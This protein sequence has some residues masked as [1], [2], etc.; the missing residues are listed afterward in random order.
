MRN[1]GI[2]A[3]LFC[4]LYSSHAIDPAKIDQ[5]PTVEFP[6]RIGIFAQTPYG[7][8]YGICL[9][10]TPHTEYFTGIQ[11]A[12][13]GEDQQE[14]ENRG[15]WIGWHGELQNQYGMQIA[16]LNRT[17][18]NGTAQIAVGANYAGKIC[19]IQAAGLLNQSQTL[20][21]TQIAALGNLADTANGF[22]L[23][24]LLNQAES[25]SGAQIALFNVTGAPL[26]L[27][28]LLNEP[29]E[30]QTGFVFQLGLE[31]YSVNRKVLQIGLYNDKSEPGFQI[32]L[33]NHSRTGWINWMPL[34]NW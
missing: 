6:P 10:G 8:T 7:N 24:V 21:G 19:G 32:G 9:A 20:N 17:W 26:E 30:L 15:L 25:G 12:F 18:G 1:L 14:K 11:L 3:I 4:L 33:L 23:S 29:G 27:P 28:Q 31:N 13:A 5:K 22:Q 2:F 34:I 16:L